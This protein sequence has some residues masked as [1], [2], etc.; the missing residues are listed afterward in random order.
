MCTPRETPG[1][2]QS[3]E[4][5]LHHRKGMGASLD[6]RGVRSSALPAPA[7]LACRGQRCLCPT[8]ATSS[9]TAD[10]YGI[11]IGSGFDSTEK[12]SRWG[13]AGWSGWKAAGRSSRA[14]TV[15]KSCKAKSTTGRVAVLVTAKKCLSLILLPCVYKHYVCIKCITQWQKHWLE[16]ASWGLLSNLLLKAEPLPTLYQVSP[17]FVQPGLG[18][19][20]AQHPPSFLGD[21]FPCCTTLQMRKPFLRSSLSLQKKKK[22]I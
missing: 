21:L 4:S 22:Y 11:S 10:T 14:E 13:K 8:Q 7:P 16:E 19:L 18:I 12:S 3:A 2:G 5:L 6:Q 17:S 20:Q 9:A 1:A 15:T